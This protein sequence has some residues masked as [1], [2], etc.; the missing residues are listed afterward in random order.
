MNGLQYCILYRIRYNGSGGIQQE[1]SIPTWNSATG[2][3]VY[4]TEITT[5]CNVEVTEKGCIK[6]TPQNMELLRSHCGC[7]SFPEQNEGLCH[8]WYR[9]SGLIPQPY[10]Y[11]GYWNVNAADRSIIHIFRFD[12]GHVNRNFNSPFRNNI[13]QVIVSYQT[14]GETPGDEIMVPQYAQMAME[15]GI[16]WQQKFYNNRVSPNDKAAAKIEWQA[17][18][19]DVNKHL[20]PI[21]MED[22]AKLQTQARRW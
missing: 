9:K 8:S 21:R 4:N 6:I 14:N 20:N 22:I 19:L 2:T 18:R 7:D 10:N 1:Q 15:A 13:N 3:V 17:A 5:L 16:M 11:Y 12:N